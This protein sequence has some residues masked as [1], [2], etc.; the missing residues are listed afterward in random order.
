MFYYDGHWHA[1]DDS[2]ITTR[3]IPGA[4]KEDLKLFVEGGK[5][6]FQF[7]GN[8]HATSMHESFK[9]PDHIEAKDVSSEYKDGILTIK[10]NKPK[11]FRQEIAIK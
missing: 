7:E 2:W 3:I 1:E 8:D 4:N 9:L 5:L 11:N 6:I 10:V